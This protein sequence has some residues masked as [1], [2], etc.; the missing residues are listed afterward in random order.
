MSA[1]FWEGARTTFVLADVAAERQAQDDKW[2]SN[3][4]FP[5]GTGGSFAA[6]LRDTAQR[7]TD[8]M[9]QEGTTTWKHILRE[10]FLEAMAEED[11][12][13]LR[14]ELV[15]VAAVAVAWIEAIDRRA[16]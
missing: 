2:G 8:R 16:A 4:D 5:D 7:L 9:A 6:S 1:E 10:E 14:E 15:Q 3:R 13:Q 11:P 12:E